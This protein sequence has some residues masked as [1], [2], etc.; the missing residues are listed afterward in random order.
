MIYVYKHRDD[1]EAVTFGSK[2]EAL[3]FVTQNRLFASRVLTE[4]QNQEL[5]ALRRSATTRR[6]KAVMRRTNAARIQELMQQHACSKVW[7]YELLRRELSPDAFVPR[8]R[9]AKP[10]VS[11]QRLRAIMEEHQCSKPTAYKILHDEDAQLLTDG[12]G[13]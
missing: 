2:P 6:E 7:A 12:G 13:I 5:L 11:Q 10:K 3:D 4:E 1:E 8:A 9:G